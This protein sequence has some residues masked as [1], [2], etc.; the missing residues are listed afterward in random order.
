MKTCTPSFLPCPQAEVPASAPALRLR[1]W[2]RLL[3]LMAFVHLG[4]SAQAESPDPSCFT[5]NYAWNF[6]GKE[7]RLRTEFSW[8][9][10]RFY[11]EAPRVYSE[12]GIYTIEYPHYPIVPELAAKLRGLARRACLS[13]WQTIQLAVTFVQ[14][15]HYQAEPGEYPKFP[16]ETLADRGGDCED[17]SILLAAVLRELGYSALLVNPP[18]HMAVALAC[19]DCDGIHYDLHGRKFFYIETTSPNFEIGSSPEQYKGK[20]GQLFASDNY[21]RAQA[22]WN[23]VTRTRKP[24]QNLY[25]L[26]EDDHRQP[27]IFA[28]ESWVASAKVQTMQVHGNRQ[29][30]SVLTGIGENDSAVLPPLTWAATYWGKN[31]IP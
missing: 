23:F 27:V 10:Y 9:A 26:R 8:E 1:W 12:Y 19:Q 7:Y 14:N 22:Y 21:P 18:G 6:M 3:V 5:R 25:Y 28:G 30:S 15:L 13:E 11:D 17:L 16:F 20:K 24:A 4:Y 2:S 31:P 29:S